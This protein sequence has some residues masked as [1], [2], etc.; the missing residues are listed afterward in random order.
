VW[1]PVFLYRS[2]AWTIVSDSIIVLSAQPTR[3]KR[4]TRQRRWCDRTNHLIRS[5]K[6]AAG[7][8]ARWM[9]GEA[10][11][12]ALLQYLAVDEEGSDDQPKC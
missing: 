7:S 12:P 8:D 2:D 3:S 4:T 10:G 6:T 11:A 9:V 5:T 1:L